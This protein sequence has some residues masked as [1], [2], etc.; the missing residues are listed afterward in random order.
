[1]KN[2]PPELK[3]L[4]VYIVSI[5]AL[6]S[7]SV[8]MKIV[9]VNMSS[10]SRAANRPETIAS[11]THSSSTKAVITIVF[12]DNDPS[13]YSEGFRIMNELSLKGTNYIVAGAIDDEGSLTTKQVQEMYDAGWSISNHGKIHWNLTTRSDTEVVNIVKD[14]REML[15]KHGWVRG[16]DQFCPPYN[17]INEHDLILIRPYV[18]SVTSDKKGLNT[19]PFDRF[20]IA[21]VGAA[22]KS[23]E[24][25]KK[26]IDQ[27]ISEKA[28]MQLDFHKLGET[29]TP[30][31]YTTKD[32]EMIVKYIAQKRSEGLIDV[33][34]MSELIEK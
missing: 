11:N 6:I 28:Y 13:I 16:I 19:Q 5:A 10:T 21:R 4:L 7:I 14:G 8:G 15:A 25:I 18:H 24:E 33:K 2:V 20:R 34:T 26:T 29:K 22:E 27:A 17:G 1:M 32:F 23:V 12:D 31:V 9:L 3:S 30:L